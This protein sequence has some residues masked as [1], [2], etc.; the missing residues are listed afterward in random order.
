M[1]TA[2]YA[3]AVGRSPYDGTAIPASTADPVDNAVSTRATPSTST[4]DPRTRSDRRGTEEWLPRAPFRDPL[5]ELV[6]RGYQ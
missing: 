4:S 2:P 3:V 1:T 5:S 6:R